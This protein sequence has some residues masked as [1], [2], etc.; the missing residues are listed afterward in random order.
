MCHVHTSG[1]PGAALRTIAAQSVVGH[2]LVTRREKVMRKIVEQL[3]KDESGASLI[4]Y[5]LI[6][7]LIS[8]VGWATMRTIG[9]DLGAILT[10][11][12]TATTA[13]S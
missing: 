12:N 4:E 5:V 7:G 1:H 6:G 2:L 8:I 13:A 11:I 10:N 9:L 3:K